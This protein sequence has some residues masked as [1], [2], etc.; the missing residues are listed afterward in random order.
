MSLAPPFFYDVCFER[1]QLFFF[2]FLII[3][4]DTQLTEHIRDKSDYGMWC[5]CEMCWAE[6]DIFSHLRRFH[7]SAEAAP[8]SL[9]CLLTLPPPLYSRLF[10]RSAAAPTEMQLDWSDHNAQMYLPN[11]CM[12]TFRGEK[13]GRWRRRGGLQKQIIGNEVCA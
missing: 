4:S 1:K 12:C 2:F 13:R 11:V 9:L 8:P 5:M 6:P 7:L 3:H 10:C